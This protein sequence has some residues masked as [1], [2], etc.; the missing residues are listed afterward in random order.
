[1]LIGL[2]NDERYAALADVLLEFVDDR[3]GTRESVFSN[4][5]L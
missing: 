1:M 2:V 3:G 5:P 4:D